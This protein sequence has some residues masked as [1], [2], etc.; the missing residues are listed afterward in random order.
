MSS[1][2]QISDLRYKLASKEQENM[3]L[4]TELEGLKRLLFGQKRERFIS[5]EH[6]DQ[7]G[8][9]SNGEGPIPEEE[10]TGQE[11]T[12]TSKL[13]KKGLPK[14]KH[15]G[16]NELPSHLPVVEEV[17][18]PNLEGW[19]KEE[20]RRIGE[21]VLDTLDYHPAKL[22]I[23]RYI[24][25]KYVA[26]NEVGKEEILIA[27]PPVRALPKA[28][29]EPG[30]LA[31][32]AVEKF[33]DHLPEYRQ[34]QRYKREGVDIPP[35][36]YNQWMSSLG[37]ILTALHEEMLAELLEQD[38]L[39]ADE[40]PIKVQDPTIK[41]K[42]HK[43]YYWSLHHVEKQL[44]FFQYNKSRS[45]KA[46][47]ELLGDWNGH[48]QTDGYEV[49]KSA[50]LKT[51][52]VFCW[53]H[54]RRYFEKALD[55]DRKRAEPILKYIQKL[56]ALERQAKEQKL[57]PLRRQ[58]FRE[59]QTVP[60]LNDIKVLL[61]K[62]HDEIMPRL[63]LRK[64]TDYALK[65]WGGLTKYAY[66]GELEIDNNPIENT[67][68]PLAIGRKNYLFAGSHNG[69]KRAAA[70]YSLFGTCIKQGIN[71]YTWLRDVLVQYNPDD[72]W[73]HQKIKELLPHH[74]ADKQTQEA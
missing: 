28:I 16:R 30:L 21:E 51:T 54:A 12:D 35:S 18:E 42:T 67:I 55:N 70:F 4:R 61:D 6:P 58:K 33:C 22:H 40:T 68:R 25:P 44:V 36:T 65:L 19:N 14:K 56:Y 47:Q 59:E 60:I 8:L 3:Q 20:V 2:E 39:Q 11:E 37:V 31:Q 74:W 48:L 15:T 24:R 45:G 23:K 50:K 46:I 64:A 72:N 38:Y 49:Y 10:T 7:L 32:M 52:S 9:F 27:P 71:P 5:E 63:S 41:G 62:Y 26:K 73:N 1:A 43:G 66:S 17:L 57:T 53:A 29:A 13:T 34:L 69:A